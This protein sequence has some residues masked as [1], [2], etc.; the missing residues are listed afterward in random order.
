MEARRS[1]G[2]GG[3]TV[4]ITVVMLQPCTEKTSEIAE[5][6][7]TAQGQISVPAEVGDGWG[8]GRA[9]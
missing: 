3:L 6:R 7:L 1:S 8:S 9:R 4:P 2:K 5:S